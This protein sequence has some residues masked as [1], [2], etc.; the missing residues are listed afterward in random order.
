ML[1]ALYVRDFA[2][3][4]AL[5]L[6]LA[7][8]F[9]VLTGETGAGKSILVDA[10]MLAL[11]GRADAGLIRHG[12]A[13]ADVSAQWTLD[14]A[15]AAAQWLQQQSLADGDECVLRRVIE[16]DKGS[17]AFIN[18]RPVPA[19]ALRELGEWLV[20]VHG[21]H[22][23]HSLLKRAV[24][25]EWLD[26]YAGLSDARTHVGALYAR[27]RERE[28]LLAERARSGAERDARIE[29]LRYQVRELK[30]LGLGE[31]ELPELE[32]EHARLS[33]ATELKLGSGEAAFALYEADDGAAAQ[34]VAQARARLEALAAHDS[35]L[36]RAC[37]LLNDAAIQ[38][39]EAARDLRAY[40]EGIDADPARLDALEQR[41]GAI[42]AAARKHRVAAAEL[43]AHCA[44]LEAELATL[45][46]PGAGTEALAQEIAALRA[47]YLGHAR[48]LSERRKAA[49]Q[50]LA[51][52][53][54]RALPDL[55]MPG[56]RFEVSL[57]PLRD[58]EIGAR[59]L[60]EIE[61]Q[62]S[63]NPG[64]PPQPLA[65]VA[66][67]GELSRLSLALQM[68]AAHINPI[69]TL[70]FDEVDVGIGGRV[71]DVVGRELHTLARERQVLCVTHLAQVAARADQHLLVSKTTRKGDTL[72][73]VGALDKGARVREIARMIGGITI[74]ASTLAHAEEMLAHATG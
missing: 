71:A 52:A 72:T 74:S 33:H 27:I 31:G 6:E 39:E 70:I 65:R 60:E 15:S 29:L 56:G 2:I 20:D 41:L 16:R 30:E 68:V 57:T 8:G 50:K 40:S 32:A 9:T 43:P 66:S 42:E 54:T 58:D 12:A 67:G 18:G 47:E 36:N 64:Q 49:A 13:R 53:V 5:S 3:V 23:H 21:Q 14:P 69:P 11:G 38:I 7:P 61:F 51:R 1:S 48:V 22:E 45:T 4:H 34:R 73:E 26:A 63:A 37:A 17:K 59:G 25:G 35:R 62:F 46:D 19:Q 55:G 28:T 10:L 44:R 24:Q